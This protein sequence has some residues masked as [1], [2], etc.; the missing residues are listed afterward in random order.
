M[1]P[2]KIHYCWFGKNQLPPLAQKCIESWKKFCPNYEII[3]WNEDNFAVNACGYTKEA[4]A[5]KKWAFVSD[6]ARF[7]ILYEQ[8]GVYLDTDVELIKPI[9]EIIER[10]SLLACERDDGC[11]VNPGLI[12][13]AEPRLEIFKELIE[14][15]NGL[16]FLDKDG[17]FN[18]KTIVDHTSELLKTRG[19]KKTA[20]VQKISGLYIYPKEYFCPID[21]D[22]GKMQ[23]TP[24]TLSI[25]H[26]DGSWHS[27]AEEYAA[28]LKKKFIKFLPR[29]LS[30]RLAYFIAQ[31]KINGFSSA[32]KRTF[33]K[34]KKGKN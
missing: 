2:K 10:G 33:K 23:L 14:K 15:Y 22:S 31:V 16:N 5:C 13:A 29:K 32:I 20:E 12:A 18:S 11:S 3:E 6:Y 30:G 7:K 27:P 9:D 26:Y 4:Y 19:L 1:I 24:K 21:Y 28:E 34:L 8:G 25:H 17:F